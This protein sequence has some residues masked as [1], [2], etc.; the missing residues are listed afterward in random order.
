V[1]LEA[2]ERSYGLFKNLDYTNRRLSRFNVIVFR[3]DFGVLRAITL[4][5]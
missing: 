5:C 1:I 3:I 4:P 2:R